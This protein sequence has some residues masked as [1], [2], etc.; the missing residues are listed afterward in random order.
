M[1]AFRGR[2][3]DAYDEKSENSEG[4]V[5]DRR[6]MSALSS[7]FFSSAGFEAIKQSLQTSAFLLP[8]NH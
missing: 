2:S 5:S 3:L 7:H 4:V 1:Q 8:P 6:S